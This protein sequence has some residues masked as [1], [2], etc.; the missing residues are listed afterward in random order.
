MDTALNTYYGTNAGI[1][2]GSIEQ[3]HFMILH[4]V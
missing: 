3:T 4:L 1:S 2:I